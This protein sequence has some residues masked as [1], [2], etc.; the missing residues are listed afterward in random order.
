MRWLARLL[1][2][3]RQASG[4]DGEREK[5][6]TAG[7]PARRADAE[8]LKRAFQNI[9]D[10]EC[11][12]I[13]NDRLGK[14]T[15]LYIRSLIDIRQLQ[16]FVIAPLQNASGADLRDTIHAAH[17]TEMDSPEQ[18][19]TAA[20]KGAVIVLA[21]GR[22]WS[23]SLAS[24]LSRAVEP[25]KQEAV[26][27]GPQ[28]SFTEQV[29]NNLTLIRRRLAASSLK[30][31]RF[32][33]GG[34]SHTTVI[35]LY[36]ESLTN[37]E[38]VRIAR[39]KTAA[40]RSDAIF[41][42]SHL[43]QFMEDHI[44]SVFPQFQQ[45]D[46]PDAAAAALASGKV[47]W[48]VEN[49][50]FALIAPITFFDLFQSPE[51]YIHRWPVASFLRGVRF[52]AFLFAMFLIPFY[53][54]ITMHH[55]QMVPLDLLFVVLESRS[56]IP[57]NPFWE[58]L[59]MMLVLEILKEASLR[60]PSKSG[61][62]LGIVGGI[63]IGQAGVEANIASNLLIIHVAVTAIASFLI[64]NYLMTNSSKLIQ[65]GLLLLA[66]WLGLWGITLGL[67]L[68]LIHLNGLTSLKQPYFAPLSPFYG[69]DW[70]D[71]IVRLPL[72]RMSRRPAYLK[73][74]NPWRFG[75][76]SGRPERKG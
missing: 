41:D 63:V 5:P 50:P 35:L 71:T 11:V 39:E 51:D 48:L 15:L 27:H 10:A 26:I 6:G 56:E 37:P 12:E 75:A 18:A 42:S 30:S 33:V 34:L 70:K 13:E 7:V 73:P 46:R 21:G 38:L 69:A 66:A 32:L 17:L 29:E 22:L 62:T 74:A 67:I 58:A 1:A 40:V 16:E 8:S 65:F 53:V 31:E 9:H 52:F 44:H 60:M 24:S 55:Y 28:D 49:T 57:F 76:G 59:F 36:V 20:F 4:T 19:E 23:I 14:A 61:Q 72:K 47:V 3:L 25:S 64:P 2:F 43:S 45:T 54:A 68:V